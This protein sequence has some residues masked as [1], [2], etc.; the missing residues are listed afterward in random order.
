MRVKI[1]G[2]CRPE[3]GALAREAGADYVG[4]VLTPGFS[5]SRAGAEAAAIYAAAGTVARAGVFVDATLA[6]LCMTARSLAL[7]VVQLSGREAPELGRALRSWRGG[8]AGPQVWKVLRPTSAEA[9]LREAA[10]WADAADALLLDGYKGGSGT[11]FDWEA[12]AAVRAQ[13]PA[14]LRLIVA[15]GLTPANVSRAIELLH[16][17]I[18]DVSS[19]VESSLGMKSPEAVRAFVSAARGVADARP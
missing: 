11:S 9:L 13:L 7:D 3:D 15:G 16:P 12:V 1:C 17:D 5:R 4:V 14:E 8:A 19:G 6:Q 10:G 18:V 2:V